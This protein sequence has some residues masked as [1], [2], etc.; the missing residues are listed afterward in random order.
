MARGPHCCCSSSRP[1]KNVTPW[2]TRR[3][4]ALSMKVRA[5]GPWGRC[6]CAGDV[7]GRDG[8][9]SL[10]TCPALLCVLLLPCSPLPWHKP[11]QCLFPSPAWQQVE[12]Q[13]DG[14]RS[15]DSACGPVQYVE[16]TPNPGLKSEWAVLVALWGAVS[17]CGLSLHL[18]RAVVE[19]GGGCWMCQRGWLGLSCWC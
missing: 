1:L 12:Q 2:P 13:L 14:S 8:V 10:R 15:G 16:K 6:P 3:M 5:E 7:G 9:P 11:T 4:F 19:G 17:G 18:N